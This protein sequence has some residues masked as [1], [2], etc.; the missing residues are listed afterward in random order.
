MSYIPIAE[1]RGFTTHL[2]KLKNN[3]MVLLAVIHACV[4][5]L[6]LFADKIPLYYSSITFV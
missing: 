2:I 4:Y 6:V 5:F 1:A 3:I